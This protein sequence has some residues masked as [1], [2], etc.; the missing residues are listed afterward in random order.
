[1]LRF[2][3]RCESLKSSSIM[4]ISAKAAE[5]KLQGFD[6]ISLAAGEPDFNTPIEIQNA[7]TKAMADGITKYTP[8][9][10]FLT[11]R[12]AVADHV[13]REN[14]FPV[15]PSEVVITCGAKHALYTAIQ[16]LVN[17]GEAVLVPTPAWVSYGA[18]VE[19]A[20]GY[21]IPL[22]LLEEDGFRPN[23]ERW[24]GMALPSNVRG[25]ILNSPNNPTGAVYSRDDLMKLV[26]WALSR[27]L[28]IISDEI[29]EKITYDQLR[30]VSVA[31]LGPEVKGRTVTVS[32]FS[33]SHC[34]TGWRLG[35]TITEKDLAQKISAFT[36]QS[37]SHVTSFAQ[38]GALT[39][40]RMGHGVVDKMV[41]EFDARRQYVA[42][43][44]DKW[45]GDVAYTMPHGAFYFF[46]KCSKL[47]SRKWVNDVQMC[48]DLLANQHIGLVPGASFGSSGYV[49]LSYATSMEN[50]HRAL[51]RF[52]DYLRT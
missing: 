42:S 7:A 24:K 37:I 48:R 49:R 43:R 22:P 39:A 10:G 9:P 26:S 19:L 41:S 14:D 30:H 47:L 1:M 25:I 35:W 51:D 50:L 16:C 44:L 46:V 45:S 11:L 29:Y 13:T 32:G 12:Q 2:S 52:E 38:M 18:I 21:I 8:A 3:Q 4:E 27:D 15:E 40:A 23:V 6:V 28:W 5:L 17:P 20:G 36:S 34:M 33:K 31:S